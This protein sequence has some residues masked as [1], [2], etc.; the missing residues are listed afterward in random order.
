[1]FEFN[2]FN[3]DADGDGT[4]DS[5]YETLDMDQDGV[6]ETT[7]IDVGGDGMPDMMISDDDGNGVSESAFVDLDGD[8][9]MET[10][11]GDTDQNGVYDRFV[12]EGDSDG[13]GVS[14]QFAKFNDYDQD[15]VQESGV[16]YTDLDGDGQFDVVSQYTDSDQDG[17][18]DDIVSNI[19]LDGDH[20][21]DLTSEEVLTDSDGDGIQDLYVSRV[22]MDGDETY[23][24]VEVYEIDPESGEMELIAA[25]DLRDI[26]FAVVDRP[27]FDPDAADPDSVCG[28]PGSDMENW[29]CQGAT[30]RCTLYSQKFVI[31]ELTGEEI[32]IEQFADI[33]GENGWF[34]EEGGGVPLNMNKMLDYYGVENEMTFHADFQD[35]EDCLNQGG[36]V[37][38]CVDSGEIWYGETDDMFAPVDGADHAV[39]VIGIDYSNPEQPMVILNDS[40]TPDGCGEMVPLD[41]FKDAWAD[42]DNQIITC[43]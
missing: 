3:F 11:M 20:Q 1:M 30:N 13:D 18:V 15:G 39:Q 40:G 14:D 24:A 29:E 34:S 9:V 42:G 4:M 17:V 36:K 38:V 23:D 22:D 8:G 31:E 19:D 26:D 33:A 37:I 25:E 10:Y 43:Y 21:A 5:L 12:S 35:I 6:E 7:V 27:C 2:H 32:D 16:I 41:V 28:D